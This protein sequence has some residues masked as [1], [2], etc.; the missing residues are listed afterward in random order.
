[1]LRMSETLAGGTPVVVSAT[2]RPQAAI[3]SCRALPVPALTV[4]GPDSL[5]HNMGHVAAPPSRLV[6]APASR[7][8]GNKLSG[9]QGKQ[10]K[11]PKRRSHWPFGSGRYSKKHPRTTVT[12]TV[13]R[14]RKKES[15]FVALRTTQKLAAVA[16]SELERGIV[17]VFAGSSLRQGGTC[18]RTRSC[19]SRPL[20]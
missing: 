1:M 9:R 3:E 7:V 6:P 19:R 11:D 4:C 16:Q 15:A 8:V 17:T 10:E 5:I 12:E 2:S 13:K 20:L 14:P 18:S